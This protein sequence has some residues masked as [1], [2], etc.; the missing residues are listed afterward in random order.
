MFSSKPPP[1]MWASALMPDE[2]PGVFHV[3]ARGFHQRLFEGL[4]VKR[5]RRAAAS[6]FNAFAHQAEAIGMHAAAGQTQHHVAAFNRCAGQD[7]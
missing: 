6:A 3:E 1:V 4:A 2:D 7:L 5:S